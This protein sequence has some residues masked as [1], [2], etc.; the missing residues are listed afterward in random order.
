MEHGARRRAPGELART[1]ALGSSRGV[2]PRSGAAGDLR[3]PADTRRSGAA[4]GGYCDTMK[5]RRPHR[6]SGPATLR[7]AALAPALAGALAAGACAEDGA[8]G[9]AVRDDPRVC[10]SIGCRSGVGFHLEELPSDARRVVA[11]AA[12]HCRTLRRARGRPPAFAFVAIEDV[13]R[14]RQVQVRLRVHTPDLPAPRLTEISAR[15]RAERPNGAG[16]PPVCFQASVRYDATARRLYEAPTI[17]PR[18][19]P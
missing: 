12:G 13:R 8:D 4:R 18:P 3:R 19:V 5:P 9:G 16:C 1:A 2:V 6:L 11:C 17:P 14:E 7:R 10:T 15:L